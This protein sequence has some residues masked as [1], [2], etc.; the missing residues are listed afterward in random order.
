MGVEVETLADL[1]APGLR[2]VVVGINPS[3]VSVE[4]GHYY[5]GRVGQT[6]FRRLETA[7]VV[8]TGSGYEDDRA[9][10]AGLGFTDVVKRPT[11]RADGIPASEFEHGRRLLLAKLEKLEIPRVIFTFKRS[12][13]A[14]LGRFGGHGLRPGRPLAGAEAFVMPGPMARR[15]LVAAALEE[16]KEWWR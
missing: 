16:L 5:Q 1:L 4:A 12:A 13:E 9:F 3:P 2:G 8:P 10:G 11:P 14:L 6:F 15:E 7:S